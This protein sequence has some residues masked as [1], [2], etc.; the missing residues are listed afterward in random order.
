MNSTYSTL[1]TP[2]AHTYK[3]STGMGTCTYTLCSFTC[4]LNVYYDS[5]QFD[6]FKGH[7][8][9]PS[10]K[11]DVTLDLFYNCAT[12]HHSTFNRS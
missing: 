9:D 3:Y 10:S 1:Y 8:R 6:R 5:L 12:F 4:T 7:V 11:L 2:L